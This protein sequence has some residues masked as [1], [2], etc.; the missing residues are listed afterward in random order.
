MKMFP[1]LFGYRIKEEIESV[2]NAGGTSIVIA[3]PW[4]MIEPHERQAIK[5]H[6]QT[7]ARLAER[8]GLAPCEACAILDDREYRDMAPP[9]A[10]A[11]LK[12]LFSKWVA[13]NL[14]SD[15]VGPTTNG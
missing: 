1:L 15:H 7:L 10:H 3:L 5:N 14:Q 2:I 6:S 9:V 13:E 11:R 8:G 12:E 4:S